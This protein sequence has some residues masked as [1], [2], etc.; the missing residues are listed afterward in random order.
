M[1]EDSTPQVNAPDEDLDAVNAP[2]EDLDA[3]SKVSIWTHIY[4][5]MNLSFS[6]EEKPHEENGQ[7]KIDKLKDFTKKVIQYSNH[8]TS[9]NT[10]DDVEVFLLELGDKLRKDF[11][12]ITGD[13]NDAYESYKFLQKPF[14]QFQY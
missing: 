6:D 5:R 7:I 12:E 11:L 8:E 9:L 10:E 4:Y 1:N 2:D 13:E 3:S 14:R